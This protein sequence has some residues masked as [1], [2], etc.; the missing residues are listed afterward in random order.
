MDV[1]NDW[2]NQSIQ[3]MDVWN[4]R[5][6]ANHIYNGSIYT[7]DGCIQLIDQFIGVCNCSMYT[8]N[9]CI[10]PIDVWDPLC[11]NVY[12]HLIEVYRILLYHCNN[13]CIQPIDVYNWWMYTDYQWI[14]I[15]DVFNKWTNTWMYTTDEFNKIMLQF[16]INYKIEK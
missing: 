15:I 14:Q 9:Q 13:W 5:M 3:W 1:C 16:S 7:T 10:Q 6:Y 2:Y 4:W 12:L 8:T 11:T